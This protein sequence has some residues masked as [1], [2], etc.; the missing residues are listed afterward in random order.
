MSSSEANW[1]LLLLEI[2]NL[3]VCSLKCKKISNYPRF[4]SCWL[5]KCFSEFRWESESCWP[6]I[7][8][9]K[10]LVFFKPPICHFVAQSNSM[11]MFTLQSEVIQIQ[12]FTLMWP[13]SHFFIKV[14]TTQI[15]FFPMWPRPLEYVVLNPICARCF[16]THLVHIGFVPDP[17]WADIRSGY[18]RTF[19]RFSC[20]MCGYT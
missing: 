18:I 4:A 19:S 17:V 1:L 13:E 12:I 8:I 14:W 2:S 15:A 10:E 20:Y 3:N 9:F 5:F 7:V 11:A 6:L 16:Q